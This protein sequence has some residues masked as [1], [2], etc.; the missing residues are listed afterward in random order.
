MR[1]IN[2]RGLSKS[3]RRSQ[4]SSTGSHQQYAFVLCGHNVNQSWSGRTEAG[5]AEGHVPDL[6]DPAQPQV[7]S[8]AREVN[9]SWM[10]AGS[11][12]RTQ[13]RQTR[14]FRTQGW[15]TLP[16][17]PASHV[18]IDSHALNGHA[19]PKVIPSAS[20]AGRSQIFSAA[21]RKDVCCHCAQMGGEKRA[22]LQGHRMACFFGRLRAGPKT[23]AAYRGS[24]IPH[25]Y[26]CTKNQTS[27]H[28]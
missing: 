9:S 10:I 26:C 28:V 15:Q 4:T 21:L 11:F 5:F 18:T 1:Q 25:G 20:K 27:N 19:N 17:W 6:G 3:S 14:C 8:I 24:K 12:F 22:A 7:C 13:G 16:L 2:S 23:P